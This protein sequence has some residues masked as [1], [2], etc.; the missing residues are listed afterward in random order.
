LAIS[1]RLHLYPAEPA[2]VLDNAAWAKTTAGDTRGYAGFI[3]IGTPAVVGGDLWVKTDKLDVAVQL[4][5]ANS[6]LYGQL[7][8]AGGYTPASGTEFAVTLF[9]VEQ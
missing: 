2:A 1:N 8:T 6:D 3:D 7:V 9:S 5:A 4:D